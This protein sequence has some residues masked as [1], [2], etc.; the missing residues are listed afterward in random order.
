MSLTRKADIPKPEQNG[1]S[2]PPR[3]SPSE[4]RHLELF[5]RQAPKSCGRRDKISPY[6]A[7]ASEEQEKRDRLGA[8]PDD[9]VARK[10][11]AVSAPASS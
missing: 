2:K 10:W 3:N 6:L 4:H 5:T 7:E 8:F 11:M 1:K 9:P